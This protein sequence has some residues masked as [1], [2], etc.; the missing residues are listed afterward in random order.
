MQNNITYYLY[1]KIKFGN[2][3]LK[4]LGK[5][6]MYNILLLP[7]QKLIMFDNVLLMSSTIIKILDMFYIILYLKVVRSI[8]SF[9]YHRQTY[10]F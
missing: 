5:Y 10:L 1:Y 8:N 2:L 4:N 9:F 3:L 7:I 6:K